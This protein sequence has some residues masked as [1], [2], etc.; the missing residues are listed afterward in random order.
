MTHTEGLQAKPPIDRDDYSGQ[1]A[2]DLA[3]IPDRL[4]ASELVS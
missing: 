3:T 1:Y 2:L 4:V